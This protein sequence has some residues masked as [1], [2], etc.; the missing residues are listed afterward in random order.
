MKNRLLQIA[1]KRK[2]SAQM[3]FVHYLYHEIAWEQ[4]LIQFT[5]DLDLPAIDDF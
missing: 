2:S 1:K 3:K 4:Q 5:L